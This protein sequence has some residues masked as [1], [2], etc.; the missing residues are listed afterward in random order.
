M[1]RLQPSVVGVSSVL[2]VSRHDLEGVGCGHCGHCS[3]CGRGEESFRDVGL[4]KDDGGEN[5]GQYAGEY[6]LEATV[7][8]LSN[9]CRV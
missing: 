2:R 1:K 8:R 6:P 3:D 4:S 5:D 7:G 9:W